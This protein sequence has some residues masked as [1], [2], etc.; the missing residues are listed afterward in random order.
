[1]KISK[2]KLKELY[3]SQDNKQTCEYLGITNATLITYLKKLG[4]PR[5][6]KGNRRSITKIELKI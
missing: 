5:K 4:I 3:Y 2:E 6:G 1:M